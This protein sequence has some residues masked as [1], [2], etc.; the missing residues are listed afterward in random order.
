MGADTLFEHAFIEDAAEHAEGTLITFGG[1]P[2]A[3]LEGS[4]HAFS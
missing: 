1:V 2:P 3:L 4:G